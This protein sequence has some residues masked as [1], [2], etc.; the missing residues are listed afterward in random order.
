MTTFI[1]HSALVAALAKA[2]GLAPDFTLTLARSSA[3]EC[4]LKVHALI[5]PSLN[6]HLVLHLFEAT[7]VAEQLNTLM[8]VVEN[9]SW[10]RRLQLLGAVGIV[11][12]STC[13]FLRELNS[14]RGQYAHKLK[15][16]N[17]PLRSMYADQKAA[18]A[19]LAKLRLLDVS[20]EERLLDVD[21]LD[22]VRLVLSADIAIW[23]LHLARKGETYELYSY[24]T[25]H[26]PTDNGVVLQVVDIRRKQ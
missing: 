1:D 17:A 21:N 19:G 6:E 10:D 18:K 5:E 14:L 4:V 26:R 16:I 9:M 2:R 7:L 22:R 3:W 20:D 25:V 15:A 8:N 11:P 24:R 13:S 23:H 12:K